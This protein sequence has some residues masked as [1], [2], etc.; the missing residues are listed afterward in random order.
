M[1]YVINIVWFNKIQEKKSIARFTATSGSSINVKSKVR[2]PLKSRLRKS[3]AR[4]TETKKKKIN[5]SNTSWCDFTKSESFKQKSYM[6]KIDLTKQIQIC[7]RT[8]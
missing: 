8:N 3:K 1:L 5:K 6:S 4:V 2:I 7:S